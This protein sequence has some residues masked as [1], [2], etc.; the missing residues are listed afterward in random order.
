MKV[1]TLAISLAAL[2]LSACGGLENESS[3]ADN[4]TEQADE[5]CM[6][7]YNS[8]ETIFT[9]TAFKLTDRVA[10]SG[11]FDEINVETENKEAD[12]MFDV[13]IGAT[14]S[15]DPNS[16]DSQDE[17]RD[18]K[19]RNSF[20]GVMNDTKMITG[21]VVDMDKQKGKVDVTMNGVTKGYTGDVK[22]N[23]QYI[24]LLTTINVLDFDAQASMD[25][26][27]VVCEEKHTGPDG[28]NILW[29]DVEIA[30]KTK[31]NKTCK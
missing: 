27:S 13:L 24:T 3:T 26:I 7:S 23:E 20:F 30:V 10:V 16:I 15:I 19:L 17:T 28:V 12:N 8:D 31:L 4:G 18:P 22:I 11:T 21:T 6:Y 25:S 14:F 9:W 29:T 2:F 1:Y 5:N